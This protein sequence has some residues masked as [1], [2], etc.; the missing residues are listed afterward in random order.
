MV[1]R[2]TKVTKCP[3]LEIVRCRVKQLNIRGNIIKD[4]CRK[5][6]NKIYDSAKGISL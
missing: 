3:K 4:R 5:A 6:V 1:K 2:I